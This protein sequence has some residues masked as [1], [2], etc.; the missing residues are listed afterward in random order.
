MSSII[1]V[2]CTDEKDVGVRIAKASAFRM[3]KKCLFSTSTI[4]DCVKGMIYQSLI[5]TILLYGLKCWC[6]AEAMLRKICNFHH[7][8]VHI[9]CRINRLHTYLYR[10]S[11]IEVLERFSLASIETYIYRQQLRWA[12][13]VRRMQWNRLPINGI[14][15]RVGS[16]TSKNVVILGSLK[17]TERLPQN[18]LGD[19]LE[20]VY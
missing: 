8:C 15:A 3:L 4:N 14:Y 2:D 20:N 13:H 6:I 12:G 1:T 11:T 10:I 18:D 5:L 17:A 9:M 16:F 19:Q 7:N